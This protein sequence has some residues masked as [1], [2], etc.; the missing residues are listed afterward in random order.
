MKNICFT[1]RNIDCGG[2]TER[3]GLRLANALCDVGYNVWMVDYDSKQHKPF[4]SVHPRLKLW[5]I[6]SHGGFERK[7]RWHFWYGSW[8]LRRFLKREK[9]DVVIDI[10]TFNALWTAKAVRDLDIKWISWDHFNYSYSKGDQ[11][12]EALQLVQDG[13]ACLV[14]LSKAD[15]E[16]YLHETTF[17]PEFLKQIYNPLSFEVDH[18]IDHRGQKK[19]M[20]MGRISQQKGFDLLLKSWLLV[21]KVFKDWNLEIVCGYGDYR[22]LESEAKSMGCRNVSCT[23]PTSDVQTKMSESAI[24]AL[25]SRFEGFGLVITE[26]AA[27]SVPTVSFDCP[28]GPNEIIQDGE[29]GLLVE[30]ENVEQF[31]EKLLY[32]MQNDELRAKMG[33]KAYENSKRFSM[34]VILPQWQSLIG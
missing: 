15:R 33:E 20:A 4:F 16:T 12:Q 8:K 7:M 6:L 29:D 11:R 30:P 14:L 32:L 25:S 27:C 31:A 13:A 17:K 26:A 1:I 3:V 34:K 10:D 9:I 5:T 2:G 23:G 22:V 18:P 28:C 21:E 19:V 24:F